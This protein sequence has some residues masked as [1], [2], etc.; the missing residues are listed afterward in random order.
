MDVLEQLGST[1]SFE[2]LKEE[3]LSAFDAVEALESLSPCPETNAAFE[4]LVNL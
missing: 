4:R 2:K 1:P 3:L